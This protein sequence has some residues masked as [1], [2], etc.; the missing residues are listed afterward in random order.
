M[1]GR[2]RTRWSV[3][4]GLS[5]VV[6]ACVHPQPGPR[7]V[8]NDGDRIVI[9]EELIAR[10]GGQT[11]WEVLKKE[12]PQLTYG[13]RRDG[14]P[15]RLGRRGPASFLLNDAPLVFV[16]G[17]E[18]VDFARLQTLPASVLES[19]EI[20]NGLDGTTY[21]GSNA[22][23]GVILIKTKDGGSGER[24]PTREPPADHS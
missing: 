10:S 12:A 23:S 11:A 4:G 17:V 20:L 15:T 7:A 14:Q 5:A 3:V 24:P 18:I 21:Y 13:E 9:T 6:L 8:G 16:D 19:I 2:Q 22:V 1:H